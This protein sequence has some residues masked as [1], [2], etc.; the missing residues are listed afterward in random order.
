[1]SDWDANT[2]ARAVMFHVN[3]ILSF[4]DVTFD[5]TEFENREDVPSDSPFLVALEQARQKNYNEIVDL[6]SQ[7]IEKGL[8]ISD[9]S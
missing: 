7:E 1:M 4:T 2:V 5:V 3:A 8:F 6:C 9:G